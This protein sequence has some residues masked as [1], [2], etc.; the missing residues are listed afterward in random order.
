MRTGATTAIALAFVALSWVAETAAAKPIG[1]AQLRDDLDAISRQAPGASGFQVV[2]LDDGRNQVLFQRREDAER[3][4]ASNMKLFTTAAGLDALGGRGRIETA[5]KGAEIRKDGV[6]GGDLYLV[7][8]GD[9]TLGGRGIRR[10][11]AELARD[12]LE[13]VAGGLVADASLFDGKRGVPGTGYEADEDIPPLSALVYSGSS[14]STD[15]A[16]EAALALEAKLRRK[17]IKIA[18]EVKLG[19]LP[20]QLKKEEPLAVT[21]S[22]PIA[23]I[24][25]ATNVPSNNF[26]AEM[27]TKLLATLDG[28]R[29]T[30]AAG[31][32]EIE[33]FADSVGSAVNALDGSGLTKGNRS[34]PRNVVRLLDAMHGHPEGRAFFESLPVAGQ[35]GTLDDRMEGTA[36]AGECRAKTGTISGVSTLSGYC[37]IGKAGDLVAFS[38]LMNGVS[39][40]DAARDVQDR[41]VAR[42]AKYRP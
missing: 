27:L 35:E 22:P 38:L 34:T 2:E 3:K 17:R 32:D 31:V 20:N 12:G 21:A 23:E 13:R 42:I 9:P 15:P 4:L 8:G 1:A 6:L 5:V 37:D 25:D 28:G 41:M 36:A 16:R 18:G 40:Y 29:G 11:A 33:R 39:S 10:L 19:R 24:A 7:G 30:T 14:Y 26:Y